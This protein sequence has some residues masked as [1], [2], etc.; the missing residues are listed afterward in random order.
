MNEHEQVCI[1]MADDDPDD[2]MMADQALHQSRLMNSIEFVQDGQELMDYL[3]HAGAYAETEGNRFPT[4][5]LCV[6]L[7]RRPPDRFAQQSG[8]YRRARDPG[9]RRTQAGAG[10]SD[11]AQLPVRQ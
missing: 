7:A 2:R 10:D 11:G 8:R 4:P 3:N 5:D 1:L 9:S 6:P